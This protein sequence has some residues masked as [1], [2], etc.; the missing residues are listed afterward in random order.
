MIDSLLAGGALFFVVWTAV[1]VVAGRR[2]P[3]GRPVRIAIG[4]LGLLIAAAGAVGTGNDPAATIAAGIAGLVVGLFMPARWRP[5]GSVF[6]GQLLVVAAIYVVYLGQATV[7]L[8]RDPIGLALGTILFLVE[9]G[10]L[11]LIVAAAFEMVDALCS[12]PAEL[13]APLAPDRWPVVCLQVPA[14]NEPPELL[15]ETIASLVAIDYP[16][17]RIQVIDNNTASDGL[18]RPVED[19]CEQLRSAGH[20]IEFVHLPTWPG[21]KAGAMNWGR[22]HLPADVEIVGIVDADYIVDRGFLRATIPYFGDPS[23]AFVQTPQDYRAWA[24]ARSTPPAMSA[25]STS[26]RSGW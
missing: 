16:N 10:A 17:L 3:A 5:V 4:L 23:V 2:G 6:F 20:A 9:L 1:L 19:A 26:S 11:G 7:L 18:W 13:V 22:E 14:H 12:V 21:Y 8:G 25:L 15:I 24:G